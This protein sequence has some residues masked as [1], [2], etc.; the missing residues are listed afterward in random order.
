MWDLS[1]NTALDTQTRDQEAEKVT[2]M[3]VREADLWS[4][5][6]GELLL[7]L[8]LIGDYNED[9]IVD[10]YFIKYFIVCHEKQICNNAKIIIVGI[11][12]QRLV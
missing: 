6:T 8:F 4:L 12:F 7:L 1:D 11:Y 5:E 3:W 2:H 10:G 9:A